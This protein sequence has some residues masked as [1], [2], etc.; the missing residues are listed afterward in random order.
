[1]TRPAPMLPWALAVLVSAWCAGCLYYGDG[2]PREAAGPGSPAGSLGTFD[3]SPLPEGPEVLDTKREE[4]FLVQKLRFKTGAAYFRIR[5]DAG[6]RPAPGVVVLPISKGDFHAR[7]LAADLASQGIATLRFR[8]DREILRVTEGKDPVGRFAADLREYVRDVLRSLDWLSRH[9]SVDPD[10]IGIAG[11]SLGAITATIVSGLDPRVKASAYLLGGGDLPGIF[12]SS[13]E[14]PIVRI[15]EWLREEGLTREE[16]EEEL[17]EKLHPFE[18]LLHAR[19]QDPSTILMLN[20]FFDR[21]IERRYA[22]ALWKALG[23]PPMVQVPTGH[24]SAIVFL[25]YPRRKTVRHFQETFSRPIEAWP[26]APA[27]SGVGGAAP[28]PRALAKGPR[29]ERESKATDSPPSRCLSLQRGTSPGRRRGPEASAR[30]GLPRWPPSGPPERR[31]PGARGSAS[32]RTLL[33]QGV[34]GAGGAPLAV[35]GGVGAPGRGERYLPRAL[36]AAKNPVRAP[37]GGEVH[38][39]RPPGSALGVGNPGLAQDGHQ[40]APLGE[41]RLEQVEPDEGGEQVPVRGVQ[42]AQAQGKKNEEPRGEPKTVVD[43]HEGPLLG[44]AAPVRRGGNGS[45][46]G[47]GAEEEVTRGP[48]VGPS[49]RGDGGTPGDARATSA[50]RGRRQTRCSAPASPE[51][52]SSPRPIGPPRS[53]THVSRQSPGAPCRIGETARVSRRLCRSATPRA[54]HRGHGTSRI[55]GRGAGALR[56]RSGVRRRTPTRHLS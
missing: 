49:P 40:R 11:I 43:R 48:A 15:R 8:P 29:P 25:P 46:L 27:A 24:D 41:G 14:R 33:L 30:R 37:D 1:M 55:A 3:Y 6:A 4:G 51:L 54:Q 35:R 17:R 42:V 50:S 47:C 28:D 19:S 32:P 9:P 20:A 31:D 22:V 10:R 5:E 38:G 52:P 39:S 23:R 45:P 13:T 7:A 44:G 21:V 36:L 2:N 34:D 53:P 16:M 26:F 18:P 56:T 12:L